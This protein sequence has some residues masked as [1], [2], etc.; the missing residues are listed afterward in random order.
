MS[1]RGRVTNVN[2]AQI[3]LITYYD[4][5]YY[6]LLAR[7]NCIHFQSSILSIFIDKI[8]FT[9]VVNRSSTHALY[10]L[11]IQHSADSANV[12]TVNHNDQH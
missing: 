1:G 2:T 6:H 4:C 12:A 11:V 3:L 5:C 9:S 10:N 7:R 8:A